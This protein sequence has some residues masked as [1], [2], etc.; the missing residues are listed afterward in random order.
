MLTTG[1][2]FPRA[3]EQAMDGHQKSTRSKN[4]TSARPGMLT[5]AAILVGLGSLAHTITP[6]LPG[7]PPPI[8]VMETTIALLG[9]GRL[10]IVEQETVGDGPGYRL[11]GHQ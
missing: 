8:Q 1:L 3:K 2:S 7:V 5:I 11:F 4:V 6:F 10:W 9:G